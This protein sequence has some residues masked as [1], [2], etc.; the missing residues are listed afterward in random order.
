MSKFLNKTDNYQNSVPPKTGNS[1]NINDKKGKVVSFSQ[2]T[3]LHDIAHKK[4]QKQLTFMEK[5][6]RHIR[7][8]VLQKNPYLLK[9]HGD[10]TFF[11]YLDVLQYFLKNIKK[12]GTIK[13]EALYVPTSLR[14]LECGRRISYSFLF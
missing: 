7:K 9:Y 12:L 11:A 6:R 13:C 5:I 10:P 8:G 2:Q 1:V 4:Y 3:S 14:S